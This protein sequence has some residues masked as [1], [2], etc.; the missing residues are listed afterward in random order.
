MR[1]S[2]DL[3]QDS[4]VFSYHSDVQVRVVSHIN[5]S[6]IPCTVISDAEFCEEYEIRR[7]FKNGN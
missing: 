5:P 7:T 3:N 4:S 1:V 6:D 2:K